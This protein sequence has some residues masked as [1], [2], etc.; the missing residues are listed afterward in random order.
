[1]F[2]NL[3]NRLN[4]VFDE[5][6]RR[7]K[8]SEADVDVA[9]REVRLALLEADVHYSV[10]KDF[11]SRV[12]NARDWR[13]SLEGAQSG[14]AGHQDRS[15]RIDRHAGRTCAVESHRRQAACH[16]DGRLAGFR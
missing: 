6:R 7:G 16:Y 15:R 4:Q 8:L 13:G 3:T 12:Q 5:L 10:V 9:M 11:V 14:P 1:M 2:E